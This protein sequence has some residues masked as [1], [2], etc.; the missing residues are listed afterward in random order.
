MEVTALEELT[1]E[2][3]KL[4]DK[5]SARAMRDMAHHY[6]S[7]EDD[8]KAACLSYFASRISEPRCNRATAATKLLWSRTSSSR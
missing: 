6:A 2:A 4:A 7:D 3:A 8:V 5:V 1:K